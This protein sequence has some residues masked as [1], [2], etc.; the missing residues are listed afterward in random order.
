MDRDRP[1]PP[2]GRP[3]DW[4]P[5]WERSVPPSAAARLTP[6]VV[7]LVALIAFARTLMPGIAFDDWGEMQTV[8]HVLGIAHPTGYP[9]YILSARLFELFPLGSIAFRSNLYSAVLVAVALAALASV[10][11]RLGV[12]PALA[13]AAALATGAVGTVWAAA[14]VAEVNPLH[15]ALMA[16]LLE[17]ALAWADRRRPRDLALCGLLTGLALGNHLLTLFVAPWLAMFALWSGRQAL[18]ERKRLLLLPVLTG[19]VGLLVY[20]YIPIAARLDPPLP[21]NHPTTLDGF[22]FLV[23]GEQFRGQYDALLSLG[24]LGTLWNAMPDLWSLMASRATIALPIAGIAGLVVLVVRRPALGLAMAG[25]LATGVLVWA[26]YLELEHYLLVPFLVL[27]LGTAVALEALARAGRDRLPGR[28]ARAAGP[29]AVAAA[30]VLAVAIAAL[31]LPA[32]DRSSDDS[33]DAYVAKM[34]GQLPANATIFSFWGA[35]TPLWHAQLV[36]GERPDVLVVDD[37]NVVYEPGGTREERMLALIC[38]RPVYILRPY[39]AELAPTRQEFAL[40]AAFSVLVGAGGP[41]GT[42][43]LMVYQVSAVPGTCP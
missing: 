36:R 28:T 42:V 21:Y 27:G 32:A 1:R 12:R 24:S 37:T 8:P 15:L 13:G 5:V 23:T 14:T 22:L 16:L 33:G 35:S 40:H 29:A 9:T 31:S 11:L 3:P 19:F 4:D 41:S 7:F 10:A 6:L 38:S 2:V 18:V 43:P 30:A 34:F 26:N 20:V 39:D 17:R 25:I